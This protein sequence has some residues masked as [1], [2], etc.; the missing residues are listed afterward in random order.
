V[1]NKL[2]I[3]NTRPAEQAGKLSD[4]LVKAGFEAVEVPLIT[5]DPIKNKN[6]ASLEDTKYH[7]LFFSSTNGL[8]IFLGGLSNGQRKAWLQKP[9]FTLSRVTAR[10]WESLGGPIGFCSEKSSL[11]GFLSEFKPSEACCWLHPCSSLTRLNTAK[12]QEAGISVHNY[13]IYIPSLPEGSQTRLE[14][15]L[16]DADGILFYSGTAVDHFFNCVNNM[17]KALPKEPLIEKELFSFGP[18]A[19]EALMR[20]GVKNYHQAK[21]ASNES[22][23]E[24]IKSVFH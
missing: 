14:A 15:E 18:S 9:V 8:E 3:L 2:R 5:I 20:H 16:P 10:R 4:L 13:P 24:L 23:A 7:G 12:F 11:N 6:L 17:E 19:S 21:T 22:M 1:K